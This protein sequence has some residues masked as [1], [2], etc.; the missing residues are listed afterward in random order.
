MPGD[1]MHKLS[2]AVM[3][4]SPDEMYVQ[5]ASHW[6][7]PAEV[8]LGGAE[9]E[10]AATDRESIPDLDDFTERMMFLDL[11]SYLPD[12]I[13]TKVDRA[14]MAVGLELRV[15][16]L[17]HRLVEL[18]WRLPLSAK[19]ADGEGKRILR[20]VLHRRVPPAL[21]DR[22][23]MGFGLPLD[24]WLRG[25]LREWAEAQLDPFRLRSEGYFDSRLVRDEWRLHLSGSTNRQYNLWSVLMFQS[26]LEGTGNVDGSA[27]RA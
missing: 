18:A 8:V 16:L 22:P 24:D 15:P 27:P 4:R 14:S 23:K 11:V 13:L 3:A 9:P 20:K 17:D 2:H 25:P 26:W 1:R 21:V 7:N 12:D 19:I 6:N 5:L 10:C